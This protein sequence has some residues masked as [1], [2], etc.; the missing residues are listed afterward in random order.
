[1]K[2]VQLG[3]KVLDHVTTHPEQ[4]NMG[5]WGERGPC[6]TA[7]CLAGW[8]M[9]LSGYKLDKLDRFIRPDYTMVGLGDHTQEA[10]DLLG[11]TDEEWAAQD[12]HLFA[13]KPAEQAIAQFRALVEA[14]EAAP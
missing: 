13:E 11:I 10:S 14:S 5:V 1:M 9:L 7:A 4:F 2:N 8:T 6:G 12:G 3:R